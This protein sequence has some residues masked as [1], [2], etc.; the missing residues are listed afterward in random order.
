M[1]FFNALRFISASISGPDGTPSQ[2]IDYNG[3]GADGT[4]TH[5]YAGVK[6]AEQIIENGKLVS[7]N[8]VNQ[9]LYDIVQEESAASKK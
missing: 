2:V 3:H 7:T 4:Y 9:E 1:R 8:I 5:F 6:Y